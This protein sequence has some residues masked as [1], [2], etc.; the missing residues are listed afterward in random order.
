V[1]EKSKEENYVIKAKLAKNENEINMLKEHDIMRADALT[2]LSDQVIK[3][4][5]DVQ[6]LKSQR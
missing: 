4:M 6:K 2:I 1:T 5:M 3:L